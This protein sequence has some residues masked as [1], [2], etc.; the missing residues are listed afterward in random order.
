MEGTERNL[1]KWLIILGSPLLSIITFLITYYVDPLDFN[2]HSPLA[3]VPATLFSIIILIIGQNISTHFEIRNTSEYSDRIYK[4]VKDYLH[5]TSVGSPERALE[6]ISSRMVSLREVKN[7]SLNTEFESDRSDEK[8]YNTE[9]YFDM[10]K[11]I[12]LLT[13]KKL[14]WKDI[15]DNMGIVRQRYIDSIAKTN[16]KGK[17]HNYKY[18]IISHNEPQIN[19]IILEYMDGVKEVLFNWDFRGLGQDPTVLLSRDN[20]IIEMFYLHFNNLWGQASP[21]HDKTATKSTS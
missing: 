4:A 18:R 3:A 21:D 7:T 15:C 12:G 2:S 5:V 14:I 16:S 20:K 8:L 10:S 6:Y 13:S 1:I 17:K 9:T 11:Q 19:F